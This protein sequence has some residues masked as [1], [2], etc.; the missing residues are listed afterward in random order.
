MGIGVAQPLVRPLNNYAMIR[1]S[2]LL[3]LPVSP[4]FPAGCVTGD[5]SGQFSVVH[6]FNELKSAGKIP[7]IRPDER[8][9]ASSFK[10]TEKLRH[11]GWLQQFAGNCA[12]HSQKAWGAGPRPM[13]RSLGS[14]AG[15]SLFMAV[16]FRV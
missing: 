4:I 16:C 5:I 2:L 10:V 14:G 3:A 11:A 8:G 6:T 13:I 12:S 7:D 1:Y 15:M 9:E